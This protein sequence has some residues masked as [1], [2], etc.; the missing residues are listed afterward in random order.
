MGEELNLRGGGRVEPKGVDLN[1]GYGELILRG[2]GRD[3]P[4]G[5]GRVEPKV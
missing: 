1:L 4:K 2:G 5:W 3:E